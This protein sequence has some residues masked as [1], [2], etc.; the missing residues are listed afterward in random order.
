M[1]NHS[2]FNSTVLLGHQLGYP[3]AAGNGRR[4]LLSCFSLMFLESVGVV[5]N[6]YAYS[7]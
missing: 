1:E 6:C 7:K 3:T 5:L 4:W 2:G